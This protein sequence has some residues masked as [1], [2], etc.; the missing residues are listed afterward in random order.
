MMNIFTNPNGILFMDILGPL[1]AGEADS[2][3]FHAC[4]P[5]R[6][7]ALVSQY[8]QGRIRPWYFIKSTSQAR[9]LTLLLCYDSLNLNPEAT[10]N[11]SGQE[12]AEKN[13]SR[14]NNSEISSFKN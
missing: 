9:A 7:T 3:H 4:A 13:L 2:A 12:D 8:Y 5:A 6:L 10:L 11:L 14:L 1:V